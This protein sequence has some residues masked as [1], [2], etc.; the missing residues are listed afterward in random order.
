M[1]MPS[2]VLRFEFYT[3]DIYAYRLG[4]GLG[5]KPDLKTGWSLKGQT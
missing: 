5:K 2:F 4:Y 3:V 1:Q